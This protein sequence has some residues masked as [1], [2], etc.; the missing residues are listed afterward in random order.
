MGSDTKY[1]AAIR[2]SRLFNDII[3]SLGFAASANKNGRMRMG[4]FK[5]NTNI[6]PQPL[7]ITGQACCPPYHYQVK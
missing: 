6:I 7:M 3:R 2:A 1:I 5:F 4:E